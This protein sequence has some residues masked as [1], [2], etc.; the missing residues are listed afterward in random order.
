MWGDTTVL[1]VYYGKREG[2]I[3]AD[4]LHRKGD[5][6]GLQEKLQQL[7]PPNSEALDAL[8][9]CVCVFAA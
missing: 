7:Q 8:Y 5:L 2:I 6:D 9:V 1:G 3:H 4:V